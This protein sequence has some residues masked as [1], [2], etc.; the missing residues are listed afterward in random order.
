MHRKII[1][2]AAI[3]LN[4]V[5][6]RKTDLHSEP[7]FS[8]I[9]RQNGSKNR[10]KHNQAFWLYK[11]SQLRYNVYVDVTLAVTLQLLGQKKE[12]DSD[13]GRMLVTKPQIFS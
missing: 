2:L 8:E 1:H 6:F 10:Q 3:F 5:L 4:F 9:T 13:V 12:R 7:S 11:R